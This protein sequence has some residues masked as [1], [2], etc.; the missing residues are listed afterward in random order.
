M[1]EVDPTGT[2]EVPTSAPD[3]APQPESAT[4]PQGNPEE[5]ASDGD[6]VVEGVE[7]SEVK[8]EGTPSES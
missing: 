4:E 6:Q 7:E 3:P 2:P 5:L 8:E 1:G